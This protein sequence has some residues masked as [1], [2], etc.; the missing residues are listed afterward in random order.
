[1]ETT[2]YT[3]E[4]SATTHYGQ[5]IMAVKHVDLID[6]YT[7]FKDIPAVLAANTGHKDIVIISATLKVK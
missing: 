2:T 3:V 5:R 7:S 4:F 6:G 1:M